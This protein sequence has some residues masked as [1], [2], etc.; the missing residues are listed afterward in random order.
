[1]PLAPFPNRIS[2]LARPILLIL[3]ACGVARQAGNFHAISLGR[4]TK[5]IGVLMLLVC[6]SPQA[7]RWVRVGNLSVLI[8]W[9][10]G[11]TVLEVAHRD[12]PRAA[13]SLVLGALLKYA[14]LVLTPLV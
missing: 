1:V 8:A 4:S 10:I 5:W 12:G 6:L 2:H 14:L 7:H 9:L 11:F 13:V 3:A